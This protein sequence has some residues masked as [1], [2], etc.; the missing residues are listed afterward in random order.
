VTRR[1]LDG[2]SIIW[3]RSVGSVHHFNYCDKQNIHWI[4]CQGWKIN[5]L[6]NP[7]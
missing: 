7:V 2:S 5:S 6:P 4:L 3:I 1:H